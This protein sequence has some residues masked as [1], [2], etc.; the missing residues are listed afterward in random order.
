VTTRDDELK[1]VPLWKA[2]KANWPPGV[3]EIGQD[4]LNCL[5]IDRAGDIYWDGHPIEVRHFSLTYWQRVG[6]I[7]VAVSTAVAAVATSIQ[8]W[9][10]ACDLGWLL[11]GCGV[12]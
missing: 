1:M 5:G 8:A 4:E 7:T 12:E 11:T 2:N 10:A 9:S 3:R 6:A